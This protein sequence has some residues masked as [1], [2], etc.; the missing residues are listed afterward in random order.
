[1]RYL[2]VTLYLLA[3][4]GL[5]PAQLGK[6]RDVPVAGARTVVAAI[7]GAAKENA[8]RPAPRK[9]DELTEYYVRAAA[10]AAAKL[11]EA[12]RAPAF[13]LGIGVA[14]DTSALLRKAPG[15]GVLW[16][17]VESDAER[18]QRLKVIGQPTMYGRHDLTKH[19]VV[20]AA[21]TASHGARAA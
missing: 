18:A 19:F 1:M 15:T 5:A 13:L 16:K 9:G 17:K 12:Q 11:P 14:L 3:A 20:S 7:V 2:L 10:G 4:P 21:L 6:V 8:R